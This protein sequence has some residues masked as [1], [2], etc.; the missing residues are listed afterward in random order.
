MPRV[1]RSPDPGSAKRFVRDES[2]G[3]S[4]AHALIDDDADLR[5]SSQRHGQEEGCPLHDVH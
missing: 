3:S 2:L 4:R 5:R 1:K